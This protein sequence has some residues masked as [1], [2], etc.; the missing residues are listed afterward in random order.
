MII[1][2]EII[3]SNI[4]QA[5]EGFNLLKS[6]CFRRLNKARRALSFKYKYSCETLKFPFDEISRSQIGVLVYSCTRSITS[7]PV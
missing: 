2:G 6:V 4:L 1:S 3:A 7:L 5:R